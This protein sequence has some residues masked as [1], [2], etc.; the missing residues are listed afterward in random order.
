LN[1]KVTAWIK[2]L[3]AKDKTKNKLQCQKF[4]SLGQGQD[5]RLEL[6]GKDH[7]HEFNSHGEREDKK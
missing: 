3:K 6:Q 1:F 5:Q 7:N 4:T 2:N